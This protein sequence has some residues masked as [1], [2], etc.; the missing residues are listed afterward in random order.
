[1]LIEVHLFYKEQFDVGLLLEQYSAQ[2]HYFTF[3]NYKHLC[4]LNCKQFASFLLYARI[5]RH[6]ILCNFPIFSKRG[7]RIY[8]M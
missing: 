7:S 3:C 5:A 8:M 6:C 1:M 2:I 4:G